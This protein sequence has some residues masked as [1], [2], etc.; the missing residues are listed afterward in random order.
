MA[1]K[2]VYQYDLAGLY[3]GPTVADESPLEPG[4]FHIPARAVELPP[5]AEVP[6]DKWP[7]WNG[8]AWQ[9]VNRPAS[10][11]NGPVID[12]PVDKLRAFLEANPDVAA[13][14]NNDGGANA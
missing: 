5:P 10:R 14:I 8:S 6:A 11:R 7:R 3:V 12:A 1:H 4:V 9:L 2:T 13:L